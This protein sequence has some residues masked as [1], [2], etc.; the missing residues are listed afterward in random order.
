MDVMSGEC[1]KVDA[2]TDL[3]T[4]SELLQYEE[5]VYWADQAEL[6]EFVA[7]GVFRPKLLSHVNCRLVDCTWIRK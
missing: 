7:H 4:E 5:E 1:F 6:K 2:D 3:L